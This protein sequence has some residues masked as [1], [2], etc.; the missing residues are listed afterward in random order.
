[1]SESP[2][3]IGAAAG[4]P[5]PDWL[6]TL[7]SI[8]IV[9]LLVAAPLFLLRSLVAERIQL[10]QQVQAGAAASWGGAQTIAG[11][12]LEIPIVS[13][14]M[15]RGHIV[16]LPRT[17]DA[18]VE[19]TVA[20]RSRG[21]F[22]ALIYGAKITLAGRFAAPDWTSLGVL[23]SE[24]DFSRARLVIGIADNG[25]IRTAEVTLDGRPLELAPIARAG[26]VA[27]GV[28]H[29]ALA[30][31]LERLERGLP[32]EARLEL[33]G[34]GAFGIAPVGDQSTIHIAGNWP[35]PEFA[36]AFLPEARTVGKSGFEARWSVSKLARA[37]PGAWK[38]GSSSASVF[39]SLVSVRII[40]PVDLY[41][42]VDR[43][44]KYGLVVIALAFAAIGTGAVLLRAMPHPIEWLLAG[45]A[46]A[47]GFLLTLAVAEHL[48]FRWGYWIAHA[49]EV[50]MVTLYL[51]RIRRWLGLGVGA[52]LLAVHGFIYVVLGSERYA[53][54]AG[55]V[56]LTL[57]LAAAM[58][59][60][61]GVDWDRLAPL[62]PRRNGVAAAKP[63]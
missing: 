32:F 25:G 12:A 1:M 59:L 20:Q 46:V 35:H 42:Q 28:D 18:S 2:S 24:L 49:V 4:A 40:D 53:L 62:S 52:A 43:L 63:G 48:G 5:V 21:L 9:G 10:S 16:L 29:L 22:E 47:L 57:A 26:F 14:G 41:A 23:T 15:T 27:D 60:T 36:G 51:G 61:R 37:Y 11:P 55:S 56:G 30:L 7:L 3:S 38:I 58:A 54:L 17:L 50:T 19:L 45:A 6:R 44:L 33:A 39:D 34:S 8:L 31:A 13:E